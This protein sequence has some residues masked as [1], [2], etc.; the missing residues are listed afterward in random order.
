MSVQTDFIRQISK[1]AVQDMV[2][3]SR[4]G[5]TILAS[6][7]IAQACLESAYGKSALNGNYFGI[8][9]SG[10]TFQTLEYINGKWVTVTANFRSYGSME[11]SVIGH[12]QFLLENN[13]YTK[14]GVIEAGN[15]RD[16]KLACENLQKAGYATDPNYA[17]KLISIINTY[18]LYE[19]DKEADKI[20]NAQGGVSESDMETIKK[21]EAKVKSL[22]S[23][24]SL[25]NKLVKNQ[26]EPKDIPSWAKPAVDWAL[27]VGVIATPEK[28]PLLL[29]QWKLEDIQ[30]KYNY[31]TKVNT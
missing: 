14:F 6:Y 5:K 10:G 1:Y 20:L 16:W 15:K 3:T 31:H 21:L 2:R 28:L 26:L 18:K 25:V 22:E 12:S 23:E 7:T 27:E 30:M 24:L 9:G 4:L 8:K 11:A 13:R 19:Y 17:S 29:P